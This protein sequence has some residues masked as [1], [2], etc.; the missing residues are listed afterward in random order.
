MKV[1]SQTGV[2][3]YTGSSEVTALIIS[4]FLAANDQGLKDEDDDRLDWIEIF[5]VDQ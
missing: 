4:E 5:N 3:S 1:P 2:A